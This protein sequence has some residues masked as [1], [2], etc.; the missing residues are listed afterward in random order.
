[1]ARIITADEAAGLIRD[2]DTV[3]LSGFGLACVNEET[4]TAVERR[5]LENQAPRNLTV[6][7]A[8][9]V[10]NRRDK[11][12][13]HW[14][15]EGLIKRW[16]GGIAIASPA[17]AKLI[18][19]DKC[20]AYNLPQGVIAQLYR[21]I[22]AKR[23][24]LITKVGMGTFVDPRV[25]GGRM[26]PSSIDDIVQ[27]IELAG[28]GMAVLPGFPHQCRAYPW[29]G[30]RRKRKPH[31]DQGGPQDGGAADRSGGTQQRGHRHRPGRGGRGRADAGPERRQGARHPGGLPGGV[32]AGESFPDREHPLQPVVFGAVACP[33]VRH[34]P[35]A[36][37]ERKV[38][39][40]RCAMELTP[41]A[42]VN[43]GVGIPCDVGAVSAEEG[44]RRPVVLTTE[45]GGIGGVPAGLR[46]F[47]HVYNPEALVDHHAQFD[48]Y[49]GGGLDVTVLGLARAGRRRQRQRVE[50]WL[51]GGRM[52]RVHQH[53]AVREGVVFAG[54]FTSG[55]LAVEVRDGASLTIV[56]E[57]RGHKLLQQVEQITFSGPFAASRGQT[58]LYITERAVFRLIDGVVTLIEIAPGVDLQR[59]VLDQ[60]DFVPAV[61]DDLT[62]MPVGVFREQ[63][64]GWP[65][66]SPA[67]GRRPASLRPQRCDMTQKINRWSVMAGS[68]A[69]LLCTGV[70]YSF[71]VFAGPLKAEHGW[72]MAEIMMAFTING[73]IA[74]IPMILGGY[75]VDKGG[76][77]V[78]ILLGGLLF[79][80][81]FILT[82]MADSLGA[83]YLSYGLVAGLGEGFAYSGCLNNTLKLFPDKRGLAAGL[84]TGGWAPERHRR[85]DRPADL[86]NARRFHGIRRDGCRLHRDRDR[87]V[88]VRPGGPR[89]LRA[90]RLDA[91]DVH[92]RWRGRGSVDRHAAHPHLLPHLRDAGG[93]RVLRTDDRLPGIPDRQEHVR[94]RLPRRRPVSSASTRPATRWDGS[95]GARS[96]TGSVTP[97]RS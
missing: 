4:I 69:I 48:F 96:P 79:T 43:L 51:P 56:S 29:H 47:G 80:T 76:A 60:M 19:A 97:T 14:G 61:S 66:S 22:A 75:I 53:L 8:T 38:I 40:R 18:E 65:R 30:G 5:F 55:G 87:R 85:P 6:V 57:G 11:G 24:G 16:I 2:G 1:M 31:P 41:S 59:D 67:R 94:A 88:V 10:G 64:G 91:P 36:L 93:R 73:A 27:V 25:E 12:M 26:S 28:Q 52:R 15:H 23:P 7:H 44:N 17:L 83:L 34:P 39:A 92:R 84:I 82:G 42:V 78:S 54:T 74:P 89:R 32:P 71:S 35:L 49:D 81:G 3:A 50:V 90:R 95:A 77:R 9:A 13:S 58:V 20:E 72:S 21:E 70:I 63:W 86:R 46:D 33:D 37:T 45:A 68:I 62:T